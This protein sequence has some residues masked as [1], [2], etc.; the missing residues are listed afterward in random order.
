MSDF[1][2]MTFF[3][4]ILTTQFLVSGQY[5]DSRTELSQYKSPSADTGVKCTEG[6]GSFADYFRFIDDLNEKGCP[7]VKQIFLSYEPKVAELISKDNLR[8]NWALTCAE[9][10][11]KNRISEKLKAKSSKAVVFTEGKYFFPSSLSIRFSVSEDSLEEQSE[12][13]EDVMSFEVND[14]EVFLTKAEILQGISELLN[15]NKSEESKFIFESL[16]NE[17]SEFCP[18]M[19][20]KEFLEISYSVLEDMSAAEIQ[21]AVELYF[22]DENKVVEEYSPEINLQN[23]DIPNTNFLSAVSLY[24]EKEKIQGFSALKR[25]LSNHDRFGTIEDFQQLRLTETDKKTIRKLVTTLS[26]HNVF[27]LLLD[28][29][30]IEK[31]GKSIRPVHPLVFLSYIVT[32]SHM[33][34]SLSNIKKSYFKWKNFVEGFEDKMKDMALAGELVPYI[35]GFAETTGVDISTVSEYIYDKDYEGLMKHFL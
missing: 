25:G 12:L 35:R 9:N 3:S 32:D 27:Q 15:P 20:F 4:A 6:I 33:R 5:Q 18:F 13:V 14:Q 21:R 29:K 24:S 1:K 19:E 10:V 22:N 2:W 17:F 26:D 28:K 31:K 34:K 8:Y 23:A 11:A 7:T 30:E 16:E